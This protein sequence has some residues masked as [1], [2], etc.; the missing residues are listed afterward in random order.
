MLRVFDCLVFTDELDLLEERFREYQDI[1][2][3]THVICE[4]PVDSHGNPKPLHFQEHK[5][6][7]FLPYRGR[8]NHV[9]VEPWELAP[10]ISCEDSLRGFLMQGVNGEPGDIILQE[11]I[12][13]V[14]PAGAVRDLAAGRLST[15][16]ALQLRWRVFRPGELRRMLWRR[17]SALNARS[18]RSPSS[19]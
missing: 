13:P 4:A 7:R 18:R 1:P 9:T 15:R 14:P 8:W 17:G 11:D 16:D 19:K 6:N 12:Y 3:V 10:G 5:D 2:E